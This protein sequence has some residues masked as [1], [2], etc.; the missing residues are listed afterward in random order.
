DDADGDRFALLGPEPDDHRLP[1]NRAGQ[2]RSG[3]ASVIG[4]PRSAEGASFRRTTR[5]ARSD[6]TVRA[7][8]EG[9]IANG[10]RYPLTRP[11]RTA[12]DYRIRVVETKG[13]QFG[14]N[15]QIAAKEG[16]RAEE[17]RLRSGPIPDVAA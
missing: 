1:R 12:I 10:H 11:R 4:R 14:L 7:A 15:D 17:H 3:A 8:P 9:A 13:P 16:R 2:T 6:L 5:K